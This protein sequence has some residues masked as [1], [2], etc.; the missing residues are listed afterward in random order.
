[1][2]QICC[3]MPSTY[4][5]SSPLGHLLFSLTVFSSFFFFFFL[6][7]PIFETFMNLFL[8]SL[9][10][11]SLI[12]MTSLHVCLLDAFEETLV[13]ILR[14]EIKVSSMKDDLPAFSGYLWE[15]QIQNNLKLNSRLEVFFGFLFNVNL[16]CSSDL[17][18][19][20]S[21]D[22]SYSHLGRSRLRADPLVFSFIRN[23]ISHQG[24]NSGQP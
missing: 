22:L 13:Q 5:V 21:G 1:M 18:C 17:L 9:I 8:P 2:G 19:L 3:W 24:L 16:G 23:E 14:L 15:V 4:S 11:K 20:V 12:T 6:V 10:F 7:I